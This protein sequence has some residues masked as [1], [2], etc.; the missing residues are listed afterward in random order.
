MS[1]FAELSGATE[2]LTSGC[3][4]KLPNGS[5]YF[6][7][8][9]CLCSCGR[10]RTLISVLDPLMQWHDSFYMLKLSNIIVTLH[11]IVLI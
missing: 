4:V 5:T 3:C 7:L 9:I 6:R 8:S 2:K 1:F 10:N 11:E